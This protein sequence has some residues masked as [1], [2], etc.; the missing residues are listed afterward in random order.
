M[1]FTHL[2]RL[3]FSLLAFRKSE[4]NAEFPG[5]PKTHYFRRSIMSHGLCGSIKV[6][7]SPQGYKF[8]PKTE[9][10]VGA[11]LGSQRVLLTGYCGG[12]TVSRMAAY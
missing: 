5:P 2:P 7:F 3:I 9:G 12:H 11:A 6:P 1:N 4:L 10:E 8:S